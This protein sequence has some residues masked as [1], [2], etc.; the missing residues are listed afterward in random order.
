MK[1]IK[2]KIKKVSKKVEKKVKPI[3]YVWKSIVF[4]ILFFILV[5]V[6]LANHSKDLFYPIV[7]S[8]TAL[9]VGLISIVRDLFKKTSFIREYLISARNQLL[10][11]GLLLAMSAYVLHIPYVTQI[12]LIVSA[13]FYAEGGRKLGLGT[14]VGA[15]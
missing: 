10:V 2:R 9:F 14:F 12:L 1:H 3:Y 13:G 4:G 7:L 5:P 8:I 6:F 11:A 15:V